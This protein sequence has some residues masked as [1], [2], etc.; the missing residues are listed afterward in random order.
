M[1]VRTMFNATTWL[2]AIHRDDRLWDR[3]RDVASYIASR[4]D[5]HGK[6]RTSVVHIARYCG[7]TSGE[8]RRVLR[9]L[10]LLGWAMTTTNGMIVDVVATMS[11]SAMRRA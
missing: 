10:R 8:A 5:R 6:L 4:A 7:C 9:S 3:Q 11:L 1:T 2:A